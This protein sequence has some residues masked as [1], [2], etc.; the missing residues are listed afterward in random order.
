MNLR[1]QIDK[2]YKIKSQFDKIEIYVADQV[3]N[4]TLEKKMFVNY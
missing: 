1:N 4:L 3:K 2:M